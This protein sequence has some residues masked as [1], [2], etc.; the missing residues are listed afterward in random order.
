MYGLSGAVENVLKGKYGPVPPGLDINTPLL[1][2]RPPNDI[3][4]I[5]VDLCLPVMSIAAILGY[6]HLVRN[7]IERLGTDLI[8]PMEFQHMRSGERERC[9]ESASTAAL[10]WVIMANNVEM[11]KLLASIGVQFRWIMKGDLEMIF[12]KLF[13]INCKT[14]VGHVTWRAKE[15]HPEDYIFG[16]SG[17]MRREAVNCKKKKILQAIIAAGMPQDLFLPAIDL[18]IEDRLINK[19]KVEGMNSFKV[20]CEGLVSQSEVNARNY[21]YAAFW[22]Y[23]CFTSIFWNFGKNSTN[24]K[25]N[26]WISLSR[27]IL[28]GETN[29]RR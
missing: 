17:I 22:E 26:A 28:A 5:S 27:P 7:A 11:V 4:I 8:S 16:G 12:H 9:E 14:D 19:V 1:I 24:R 18:S 6:T 3:S 2:P 23:E 29:S 25:E 20:L 21:L 10:V 15:Y 13:H